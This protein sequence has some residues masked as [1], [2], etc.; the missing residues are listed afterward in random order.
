VVTIASTASVPST[1]QNQPSIA[2]EP[3]SVNQA[4]EPLLSSE[5]EKQD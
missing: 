1:L 5:H 3:P 2:S 4:F